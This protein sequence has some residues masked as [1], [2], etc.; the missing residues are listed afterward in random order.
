MISSLLLCNHRIAFSSNNQLFI[1]QKIV[2]G[3]IT[4]PPFIQKKGN[5][6]CYG[7]AID[8]LQK[9]FSEQL[10]TLT[11]YCAPPSRIYRDFNN[12]L[13]DITIN[14]KSTESLSSNVIYS[15]KPYEVLEVV[16]Y[17]QANKKN[18]KVASIRS[19]S[20]HGMRHQLESDGY[21]FVDVTNTKEAIAVFLRGGTDSILSYKQPFEH[22][23]NEG[24]EKHKYAAFNVS[25]TYKKLISVPS[26]FAVNAKTQRALEIVNKIDEYYLHQ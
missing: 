23:L 2:V 10:Y 13:I 22:Y 8:D 9:I 3:L 7:A 1:P 21:K 20:Y 18:Q 17:S 24:A 5:H 11:F 19:F 14:V 4:F 26:Y 15:Q 6:K 25:Y 12:G 16:L